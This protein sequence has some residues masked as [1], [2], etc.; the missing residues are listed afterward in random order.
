MNIRAIV[1]QG[2]IIDIAK[3]VN[4]KQNSSVIFGIKFNADNKIIGNEV[5]T[6]RDLEENL[7]TDKIGVG[8]NDD[9]NEGKTSNNK[10]SLVLDEF[11]NDIFL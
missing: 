1:D 6:K 10:F 9:D 7:T 2:K 11:E 5:S 3:N 4:N 8:Y